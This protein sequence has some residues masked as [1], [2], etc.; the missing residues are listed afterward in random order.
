MKKNKLFVDLLQ[1]CLIILMVFFSISLTSSG[2][3]VS[4]KINEIEK[5][6]ETKKNVV[7]VK[8]K[9]VH[10]NDTIYVDRELDSILNS[11]E[12]SQFLKNHKK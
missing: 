2:K 12:Y 8:Y 3:D 4:K 10:G 1:V 11:R 9:L 6:K 5:I 7:I